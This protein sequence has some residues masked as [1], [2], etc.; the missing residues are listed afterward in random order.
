MAAPDTSQFDPRTQLLPHIVDHYA[1]VKPD[2]IY[3]E[4]P[5]SLMSYDDGYRPITFKAFANAINGVAWWLTEKLGPGDGETL[6]YVGPN[7]LRYPALVLGAVKAGYRMFLTS[8]RNSVAAHRSLFECLSCTKLITPVPHPPPVKA[9][10]EAQTLETLEV[11][12]VDEL[13]SNEY[14]HFEFSK[15]YPEAAGEVLAVIHTSGSTGIPKPIF[16]THDSA[17]KHM[18][19]TVLEPPEGYESQDSWLFGKRIF[20]VPPPFHAAGLAYSLFITIPVGTT[21]I[22]PASGGLPTAASLVEARKKT[23][24]DILLGVP[25]IIQ[26]FSQ[27][28]E[29]LDYCSKHLS[30]LAYCGGDLPQPIG[31]VVASKIKLMNLYGASE[32]GMLSTIHSKTNR[33]PRTDWRYLH[34]NPQMGAELRHVADQYYELVIVRSPETERHQLTFTIFPDLQEYH[35]KDLFVR[36]PDPSKP[37]LW[38]WSSRADDVIVFLNGEKTNPVSMEQHIAASNPEVTAV[39]VAGARRF[40]ASLLVEIGGKDLTA[41][42]RAAMIEKIWPSI[43]EANAV[44]PTHARVAKTHILFTKADKPMLRAGKGTIQRAAS[45]ELY[46]SELDALYADADKLSQTASNGEPAGPGQVDDPKV[47]SDYIRRT[48]NYVTGWDITDSQNFFDLGL[49]SL[50]AITAT[51]AFKKGLNLPMLTPNLIYLHPTVQELTQAVLH[52]Q[53]HEEASAEERKETRLQQRE[54]LLQELSSQIQVSKSH[55]VILTGSTGNLGSYLLDTLLQTPSVTHVHCL[56]RSP[57]AEAI[58]HQKRNGI[59]ADL[60]R[61][62]FW[63]ADLSQPDLGLGPD[64][65]KTLRDSVTLIIHNAWAVN[66]NLSLSS[67]KPNL[68]GVVN[69]I[70][71]TSQS[72]QSPHLFFLSSISSTMGHH[73]KTG[74]T[75]E[76]VITT[77]TPGPNGY[78]DS[79][80]LAEQLLAQAAGQ[81]RVHASFA[82]VGQIAGP[83]LS[84]GVWNKTEWFPSLALSSLHLGALPDTLGPALNRIDWVPVDLL[85]EVLVDLAVAGQGVGTGPVQVYHPLNLHPVDWVVTRPVVAEALSKVSGKPIATVPFTE[86][87]QRVRQDLEMAGT[88]EMSDSEL[89]KRLAKNPAAKLLEFFE[90]IMS[91]KEREN[92]LDTRLTG[93]ASEKLRAVDAVKPEWIHKWVE[94]WVG[95]SLE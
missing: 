6:A 91:Q 59:T 65:F 10:L 62:S 45:L 14:A 80:Y 3:A 48:M 58:H 12:S 16:W 34:I 29:L 2:A 8:P 60:S 64:V 74:L 81:G 53:Q 36:H 4:Y 75:P 85:A 22:F 72:P 51:R 39:L 86:W 19:R 90:G 24:I 37:D 38:R 70:N 94:E 35:T 88:G 83:V 87:V 93:Q 71:F 54:E 26:E 73:T 41:P 33:D 76:E 56:N 50:Q 78:A 21:I 92:V 46:A 15:T 68:T 27:S 69:L 28:P 25:S 44:C 89:Q 32:V 82:R 20:L 47:L 13:I 67:F 55:V 1:K 5:V 57:D 52:M 66:F 43:E 7:D 40:Q 11:P 77:T 30:R 17:C 49:D 42:E 9:I 31:D 63:T 23:H 95:H 18:H 84:P 61:V 79:K